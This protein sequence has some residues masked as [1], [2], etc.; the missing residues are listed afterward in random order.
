M[1]EKIVTDLLTLI[2]KNPARGGLL[3]TP[4]R[5]LKAWQHWA[6]GYKESPAALLKC[7]EDGAE[8]YDEMV[9]VKSIPVY[10]K[11]ERKSM[12]KTFT[13]KAIPNFLLK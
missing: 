1:S 12:K 8:A 10:S 4:R 7:F 2:G 9:L 11:W 5:Y 3:E 6:G 13:T